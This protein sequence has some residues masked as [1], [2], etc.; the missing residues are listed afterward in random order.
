MRMEME[1]GLT[2]ISFLGIATFL[3][4]GIGW[5]VKRGRL[6]LRAMM[7]FSDRQWQFLLF[8]VANIIMLMFM[9]IPSLMPDRESVSGNPS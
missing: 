2:L 8:W 7:A 3:S 9:A 1:N 5:S 6:P 4:M